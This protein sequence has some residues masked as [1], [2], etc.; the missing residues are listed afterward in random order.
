MLHP[1]IRHPRS[2]PR[3]CPSLIHRLLPRENP[4]SPP[5]ASPPQTARLPPSPPPPT[6]YYTPPNLS[7]PPST[8]CIGV[9][10]VPIRALRPPARTSAPT[11]PSLS[12]TPVAPRRWT[13]GA[14]HG[15]EIVHGVKLGRDRWWGRKCVVGVR[16]G[17]ML[18]NRCLRSTTSRSPSP[19]GPF[20]RVGMEGSD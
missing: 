11:D 9:Q 18:R 4:L 19:T 16:N 14:S 5:P 1:T 8:R 13:I 7:K 3:Q 20:T 6:E 17:F 10:A 2:A 15:E 12:P